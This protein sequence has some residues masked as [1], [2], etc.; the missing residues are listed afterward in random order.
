MQYC[1]YLGHEGQLAYVEEHRLVGGKGDGML[2]GDPSLFRPSLPWADL[3]L[4]YKLGNSPPSGQ[5][6]DKV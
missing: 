2:S 6:L 4:D 1:D 5:G 3:R